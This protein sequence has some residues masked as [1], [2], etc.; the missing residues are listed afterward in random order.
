[1][2]ENNKKLVIYY[3]FTG[4]TRAIAES[5]SK[6]LNCDILEIKPVQDYTNYDDAVKS[7]QNNEALH[8][9]PDIQDI[10]INLNDYDEIDN[11]ME[12]L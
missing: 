12:K 4:H 7:E 5:I 8:R 10:S 6:K 3:S 9:T 11:W 1:M 2:K